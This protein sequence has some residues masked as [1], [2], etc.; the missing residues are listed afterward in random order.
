[1][2]IKLIA[3]ALATVLLGGCAT[4]YDKYIA[5]IQA[6]NQALVDSANKQSDTEKSKYMAFAYIAAKTDDPATKQMAVMAL[7]LSS[8][9]DSGNVANHMV[10]PAAPEDP[11]KSWAAI[12]VPSLTN[13]GSGF[14]SYKM[15][16]AQSNNSR[17]I[18]IASY[19]ALS[20]TSS[21]GF[22][23]NTAIA[24]GGFATVQQIASTLGQ[25]NVTINGNG[26]GA[27]LGGGTQAVTQHNCTTG[28][29]GA[30][31]SGAT[32]GSGAAGGGTTT[33]GAGGAGG[34]G[35]A[36]GAAA[37]SGAVTC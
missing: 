21:A 32:G 6:T 8:K 36:G 23:A 28:A 34:L 3:V 2:N 30:G 35:G 33:G 18:S 19:N 4:G 22:N 24:N 16:V 13:L 37:P 14:F 15:G 27:Q 11:L 29:S 26:N 10:A 7:A 1:M 20:S 12:L 31:G 9:G 5:S 17:D 25:P